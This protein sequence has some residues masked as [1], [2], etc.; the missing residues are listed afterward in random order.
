MTTQTAS[1][2]TIRIKAERDT[3]DDMMCRAETADC[4]CP[5]PCERDH[6]ND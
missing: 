4:N 3:L 1:H 5:D 6:G 2:T